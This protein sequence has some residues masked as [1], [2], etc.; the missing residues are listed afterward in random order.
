[1]PLQPAPDRYWRVSVTV[2]GWML[3]VQSGLGFLGA[4]LSIPLASSFTPDSLLPQLGPMYG[5]VDLSVV[6]DLLAQLRLISILQAL[7]NGA[8]CAGAIGLL[9]RRK[10]GWYLTVIINI[11]QAAAAIPIGQP[12][13]ERMLALLDPARAEMLGYVIAGLVALIPASIVAFL[14]L[15]PVVRQFEEDRRPQMNTD[16]PGR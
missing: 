7:A 16:G 11:L 14:L 1:L 9:L 8:I 4:L 3:A 15:K 12:P 5:G 6:A 10:W 2:L 13:V